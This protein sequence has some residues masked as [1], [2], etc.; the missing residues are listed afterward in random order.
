ML[1][2]FNSITIRWRLALTSAFLTFV[3]LAGFAVVIGEFTARGIRSDFNNSILASSD[4]LI[5]E[6][7]V[8][9]VTDNDTGVTQT[10]LATDLAAAS[11]DGA[12]INVFNA[13]GRLQ[14]SSTVPARKL[15]RPFDAGVQD[16]NGYRVNN[17]QITIVVRNTQTSFPAFVQYALPLSNIDERISKVRTFLLFGVLAGTGLALAA[18]LMLARRAMAPISTLTLITRDIARTRDPNRSVP[19]PDADDEVA[20]LARTLDGMLQALEGSRR[21]SAELL[22]RQRQFVADASHELRTPLTSVLANLEILEEVLDGDDRDIAAS[23]LRSTQRMR[24]LVADLLLLARADGAARTAK[25]EPVD[26]QGVL[27]DVAGELGPI[28][29]QHELVVDAEHAVVD[30]A[31][32]ELH[33]VVLNL[34]D[35]AIKHTP[36]GTTITAGLHVSGDRIRLSVADDGPGVAPELRDRLFERFVRGEGDRGGSF[37]LGLS[38]VRAVA[39]SHGGSVALQEPDIGTGTV[40]VVDLPLLETDVA[41]DFPPR[42]EEPSEPLA[43]VAGAGRLWSSGRRAQ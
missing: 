35:N 31:R 38:I 33:R 36:A 17:K 30:G 37:G 26:L 9:Q 8:R 23:A 13:S 25:H 21:E 11:I 3:I 22:D 19:V 43:P 16:V 4:R 6:L 18:G 5:N 34:M 39:R 27:Y 10:E 28:A 15:G 29:R 7:K 12:A 14:G 2:R 41:I 1:E 32:D 42:E 40:F 24:R 20:E